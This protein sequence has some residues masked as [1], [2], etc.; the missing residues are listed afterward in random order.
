MMTRAEKDAIA[1]DHHG[2][3]C[4]DNIGDAGKTS[5]GADSELSGW[6]GHLWQQSRGQERVM[7]LGAEKTRSTRRVT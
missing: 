7:K 3:E 5:M 2:G 4:H 1:E 6:Q